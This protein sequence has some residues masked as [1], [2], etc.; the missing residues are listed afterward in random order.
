[1]TLKSE[2]KSHET[3]PDWTVPFIVINLNLAA[4]WNYWPICQDEKKALAHYNKSIMGA[5]GTPVKETSFNLCCQA[6]IDHLMS[7][8]IHWS[9]S[10]FL[11]HRSPKLVIGLSAAAEAIFVTGRQ[12]NRAICEIAIKVWGQYIEERG[13]LGEMI[14]IETMFN[15]EF[16][17]TT[18]KGLKT[19]EKPPLNE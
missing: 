3:I 1:M 6:L 9:C 17:N 7:D 2:F 14:Y 8:W 13:C 12:M 5:C 16:T 18:P 10:N 4:Q 15:V 19:K 11:Q